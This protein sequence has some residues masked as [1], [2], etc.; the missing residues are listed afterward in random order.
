VQLRDM[1][2][3]HALTTR[4]LDLEPLR[5]EHADEMAPLLDDPRLHVFIGG[6]PPTLNELRDRYRHQ[7]VGRSADGSQLWF[8][9]VLRHRETG[10]VVGTLQATISTQ[11][12]GRPCAELSW[13]VGSADQGQGFAKE[14]VRALATWLR[15]RGV[16]CLVAHVH[17]GH[18]ASM[19][20]AR[21]I[22]LE[23]T[24]ITV[25]G[26]ARWQG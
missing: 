8:N 19:A 18:L 23:P 17:P 9:W 3:G 22:G 21:S 4:R 12:A 13:V 24:D 15:E 16:S 5:V 2:G 14:G 1:P 25:D 11:D 26:E 6:A 10:R 7:V 20:V